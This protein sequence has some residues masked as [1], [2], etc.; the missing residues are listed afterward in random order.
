MML[1]LIGKDINYSLSRQIHNLITKVNR[2]SNNYSIKDLDENSFD[3]FFKNR[4]FLKYQGL[5]ITIPYKEAVLSR[6]DLIVGIANEV[7]AVNTI[8]IKDDLLIGYNTDYC[9]FK[10]IVAK[11]TFLSKKVY[12]LGTGGAAKVC[13]KVF[14]EMGFNVVVV[15]RNKERKMPF[16]KVINYEKFFKVKK[17]DT[18]VNATPIGN[19]NNPGLLINKETQ[20]LNFVIDLNYNPLKTELMEN[21]ERSING[22]E[23]LILQ[24]IY[25]QEIWLG[26]E[27]K[28]D[29]ETI[30]FIKEGIIYE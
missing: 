29:Q 8:N 13:Y 25:A 26:R 14:L 27:L 24:A 7:K 19:I 6:L 17:I 10:D 23:M 9:A 5:N 16:K 12:I 4:E 2:L 30:D 3:E 11:E 20:K 1:A 22:L 18:L 21:A 28:K 15:T